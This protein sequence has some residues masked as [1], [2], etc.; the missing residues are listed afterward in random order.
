GAGVGGRQ[1][2]KAPAPVQGAVV[3]GWRKDPRNPRGKKWYMTLEGK[4]LTGTEAYTVANEEKRKLE[5]RGGRVTD[6]A[7]ILRSTRDVGK[8]VLDGGG[9]GEDI[10]HGGLAGKGGA[11]ESE[12]CL[13]E[14]A[15]RLETYDI[16]AEIVRSYAASGVKSLFPWQ[17]QCLRTNKGKVL[18]GGNLVYCAPTSGGKTL[19]AELLLLRTLLKKKGTMAFFVV[20]FISLAEEKQAYFKKVWAPLQLN[21][22]ALHGSDGRDSELLD[23][24]HVVVCTIERA[25]SMTNRWMEEGRTESVSMVV[26]DEAH[27]IRDGNRGFLMELTLAKFRMVSTSKS[28]QLVCLSA[29]LPNIK[30]VA[31]WIDAS[32]YTTNFRPVNLNYYVCQD[33]SVYSATPPNKKERGK[34]GIKKIGCVPFMASTK[35]NRDPDGVMDLV[36]DALVHDMSVLIFCPTK[37]WCNKLAKVLAQELRGTHLCSRSQAQGRGPGSGQ[38]NQLEGRM[39]RA[40]VGHGEGGPG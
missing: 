12:S 23:G 21:V 1:R 2:P 26:F 19:V 34:G 18:D 11:E 39:Q 30:H 31:K 16:P 33:R 32:L 15:L 4:K 8:I 27:L 37:L 28:V 17:A 25:N 7:T 35:P 40:E 3:G 38:G 20:P 36:K 5:A 14:E 10:G 22:K 24:V 6:G 9:S 13:C 29:T